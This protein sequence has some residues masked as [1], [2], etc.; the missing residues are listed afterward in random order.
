[1]LMKKSKK[2]LVK[3]IDA[4]NLKVRELEA[5]Q[6]LANNPDAD[7][8]PIRYMKHMLENAQ[9]AIGIVQDEI[10]KYVN[11]RASEIDGRPVEELIGKHM[12]I[13]T[14]PDDY[15]LAY[16][17]YYRKLRGEAVDKYRYRSFNRDGQ[18][19]WLDI[20]GTT[21]L[22]EGRPAVL[23]FVTDVTKEVR[24]EEALKK[25]ERML[26]DIVN[27]LPDPTFAIDLEGTVIAWNKEMEEMAGIKA[28]EMLGKSNYEYALPF[29][30]E[31]VPMLID[32]LH[33][34]DEI[35][36]T[37]YSYFRR[38]GNILYA[39]SSFCL[40]GQLRSLWCKVSRIYD[41]QNEPIGAIESMRD[42]T[43]LRD[44]VV[45]LKNKSLHLEEANTA[46][47]VLLEY[48]QND[49][50]EIEE[51][52]SSNIKT[53]IVPYFEKLKASGLEARQ[54]AYIRILENHMDEI[55]SPFLKKMT[56]H[57]ANLSPRE[58]QIADL[59][60]DGKSTKEI[61]TILN[62]ALHTTNNYRRRLR[63][64]L[65]LEGKDKNLRAYL[66]SFQQ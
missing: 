9:E 52:I 53:L 40:H 57:Y 60:K 64:K 39:E 47:K 31:R 46:L 42:V 50:K 21:I 16:Q 13:T 1:M 56:L 19:I 49:Q 15:P 26:W 3:E 63:K 25:S 12:R 2:D 45:E 22:W 18:V 34:P 54:E 28:E 44:M 65:S 30:G 36:E 33:N 51:R 66:L 5:L 48:R 43:D 14:H 27:F 6:P 10:H 55:I 41:H 17:N 20:I 11:K 32:L 23:N 24:A 59:V 8:I 37:R 29:Y 62:I 38:E 58:I 35:N 61:S 4:L 7:K